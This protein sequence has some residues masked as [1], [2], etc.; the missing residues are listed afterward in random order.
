MS[1]SSSFLEPS[2]FDAELLNHD[3]RSNVVGNVLHALGA[4]GY[5]PIV[6]IPDPQFA[7]VGSCVAAPRACVE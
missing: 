4:S 7:V 3:D 5:K 1:C 2:S 6:P